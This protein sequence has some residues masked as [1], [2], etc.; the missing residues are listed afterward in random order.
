MLQQ[1]PSQTVAL[2]SS[3]GGSIQSDPATDL[4]PWR[5]KP[6]DAWDKKKAAHLLRRAGFGA[7]PEELDAI[8]ALGM[9]RTVDI[10]LTPNTAPLQ[11]FGTQVLP[12]GEVLDLPYNLTDQRAQWIWEA[13]TTSYPLKEKMALFWHDHF[14]VGAESATQ[15]PLLIPHINLFRRHGLGSFRTLLVEVTKDPAML[16]WLDNYLNGQARAGQPV[17]NE[18]Y[19]RELLE[20]YTMGATAGYTQQDVVEVSKC[21]SGWSLNGPNTFMWRANY[22]VTGPKTVLGKLISNG[23]SGTQGMQDLYDL[24]DNVIL[25][26]PS[27][28][29]YM[30]TKIW[31]Y[32]VAE[33]IDVAVLTL[34]ADRWRKDSFDIRSL[35]SVI[36]RCNFFY[37]DR[38]MRTLVKNPMEYVV[39][40]IRNTGL[41]PIGYY[42]GT[43]ATNGLGYRVEQ[44]GLPLLRYS[45]PAGLDD[46]VAWIDSAALIARANFANELTQVSQTAGFRARFDPFR[47]ILRANLQTAQQIVD[48]YVS[49]LLDGD[50]PDGVRVA[51]YDFMNRVDSGPQPFTLTQAKVNEKVRGLVHLL[52]A[53][54]EYQI[55]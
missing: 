40:A 13:A 9:D 15:T 19:G 37:S 42:K 17:I 38:S 16:Y 53:T 4:A 24:L 27:T 41:T 54:P 6:G 51:L 49:I 8:V 48:H 36:L 5:P 7:K 22:H 28:A 35:M 14:S 11:A 3:G 10:L 18:N 1:G 33:T 46:G 29:E 39:G 25:P 43:N 12:N 23:N 20:L 45:N 30:V 2:G 26:Y 55:N 32:F 21:L 47:E 34:L 44:M 52:L 31:N 50:V